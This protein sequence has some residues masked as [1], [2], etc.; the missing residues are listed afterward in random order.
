VSEYT[1]YVTPNTFGEIKN[2]PGKMR[3]RVKQAIRDLAENPRP[4]PSKMLEFSSFERELWRLRIDNWRIIYT[5]TE[6]EKI[7]DVLT[8]RKRPP[9]DYGD[10]ATL[11][12]DLD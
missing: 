10:L 4:F 5:I 7:I 11:L 2:L 12:E 9:Y 3:Q 8:V 6:A 1:V